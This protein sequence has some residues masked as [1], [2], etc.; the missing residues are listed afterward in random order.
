MPNLILASTSP[1]RREQ[2]AKLGVPFRYV[3]PGVD[4]DRY[5]DGSLAPRELAAKLAQEKAAAV[6]RH[7]PDAWTLGGDQVA[8]CQGQILSKPGTVERA[9]AQLEFLAGKEHELST[10]ICLW[11]P[12]F[13]VTHTDIAILKMRKLTR[14]EIGRYIAADNPLDCAGS[15]KIESRGVLL[16]E[17]IATA[18]WT[19]ITGVPLIALTTL[20]R[21]RGFAVP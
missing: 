17:S 5:K 12:T 9:I 1:Y 19:A 2:L 11:S 20:L 3:A 21:E 4:E 6:G 15:F 13:S 16:F 14:A 10:S 8:S 18:D 7:E